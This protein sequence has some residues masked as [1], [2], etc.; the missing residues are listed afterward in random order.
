MI[1]L[2]YIPQY[3]IRFLYLINN[4]YFSVGCS[5]FREAIGIP[6]GSAPAPFFANLFLSY[7]EWQYIKELS[8]HNHL[9]ARKF[10]YT[11][12][13]IDDLITINS[14]N[15]FQNNIKNIYP[16]ELELK[17][18]SAS[19]S[20]ATF[21]DLSKKIEN[22][23]FFTCLYDKRDD[24]NFHIVRMPYKDSLMPKKMFQSTINA[25]I[26]RVCKATTKYENFVLSV[27]ILIARMKKQGAHIQDDFQRHEMF[28]KKFSCSYDT[29]VK[30]FVF[31]IIFKITD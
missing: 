19:K 3:H 28:F 2:L 11:F 31:Q 25:E 7:F 23:K 24:F 16:P 21:L 27:R 6:M 26:L 29:A 8:K 30:D 22:S 9:L 15:H 12:R 1:F 13:Y 18:E 20:E 10:S 17:K 14:A 5:T 4:C